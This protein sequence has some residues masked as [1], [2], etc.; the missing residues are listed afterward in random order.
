MTVLR[1][2]MLAQYFFAK[3]SNDKKSGRMMKMNEME[4]KTMKALPH[5]NIK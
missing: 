3:K 1:Q 5:S 2:A 4:E